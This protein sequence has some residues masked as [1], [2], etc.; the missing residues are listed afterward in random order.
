MKFCVKNKLLSLGGSSTVKDENGN[1]IFKVKGKVFSLT[2]KK[3]I[4]NMEGKLL[5]VVKNKLI[6]WWTPRR[7]NRWQGQKSWNKSWI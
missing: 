4:Y 5:Y 1:D 6:N 3:K 2:K 7:A